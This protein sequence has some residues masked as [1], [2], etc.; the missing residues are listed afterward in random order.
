M[1][2]TVLTACEAQTTH[3]GLLNIL[4]AGVST[5]WANQFPTVIGVNVAALLEVVAVIDE[6]IRIQLSVTARSD[7][8]EV[9]SGTNTI[10][11]IPDA[12]PSDRVGA[13]VNAPLHMPLAF[14]AEAAG[15]YD[16]TLVATTDSGD[17]ASAGITFAI[18]LA[19]LSP[20][21]SP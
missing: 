5:V 11:P 14:P 21:P 7:S 9:L 2:F 20:Q 19:P 4:G 17:E 18:E 3:D 1:R 16:V 12:I 13:V 15:L 6:P 8:R 10:V